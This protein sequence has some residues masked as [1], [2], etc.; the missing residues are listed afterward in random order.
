MSRPNHKFK[1]VIGHIVHRLFA[2]CLLESADENE[3]KVVA[4][5]T[6]KEIFSET[7]VND[8]AMSSDKHW[9]MGCR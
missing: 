4:V 5:P 8:A 6:A 1:K 2:S 9:E 3:T 7:V